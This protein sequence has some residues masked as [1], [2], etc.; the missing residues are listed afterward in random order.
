MAVGK[1]KREGDLGLFY[2]PGSVIMPAI[3][4]NREQQRALEEVS[5]ALEELSAINTVTSDGWPGTICVVFNTEGKKGRGSTTKVQFGKPTS[6]EGAAIIRLV[7]GYAARLGKEALSKAQKNDILLEASEK[8]I[9]KGESSPVAEESNDTTAVG[10]VVQESVPEAPA[11]D[12]IEPL[13]TGFEDPQ[14]PSGVWETGGEELG[15]GEAD[16]TGFDDAL[17]SFQNY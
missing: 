12:A 14:E 8:A 17:R 11:A 9:L 10:Q 1:M 4:Q 6:K 13:A 7:K 2:V 5:K 15:A 16:E 3:K